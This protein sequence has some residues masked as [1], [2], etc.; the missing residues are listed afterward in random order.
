MWWIGSVISASVTVA[1]VVAMLVIKRGG[2]RRLRDRC[3]AGSRVLVVG[4]VAGLADVDLVAGPPGALFEAVA[5]VG[6]VRGGQP[7][8][9]GREVFALPPLHLRP[10][11]GHGAVV[12]LHPH[13]AQDLHRRELA[14]PGRRV[15]RVHRL[16]QREPV[17]A[18][19][20]GHLLALAR[21]SRRMPGVESAGRSVRPIP[22]RAPP[23]PASPGPRRPAPP[24][25]PAASP[26]PAP[27][28]SDRVPPPARG[29]SRCAACLR[30]F[31]RPRSL[32]AVSSRSSTFSS[33][34][35]STSRVAELGQHRDVEPGIIQLQAERVL[36]GPCRT[37]PDALPP[38]R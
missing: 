35:C 1:S 8:S 21:G 6:V 11:L 20:Q 19:G 32:S 9:A 17:P 3:L 28:G 36:P 30:A 10:G 15:R 38:G 18:V 31:T 34:P 14:Q 33:I 26:R 4:F 7:E 25:R 23:R 12:V 5:G 22:E 37:A 24:A 13:R 29:W 2:G 27:A 16:Q